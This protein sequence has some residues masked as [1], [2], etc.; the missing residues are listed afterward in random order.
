MNV[1]NVINVINARPM[2]PFKRMLINVQVCKCV[3]AG[4]KPQATSHKFNPLVF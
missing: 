3:N 1:T 4:R 2:T